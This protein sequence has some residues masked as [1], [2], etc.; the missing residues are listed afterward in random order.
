MG[1]IRFSCLA[2]LTFLCAS[3]CALSAEINLL[4]LSEKT[5]REFSNLGELPANQPITVLRVTSGHVPDV[6][7]P[8]TPGSVESQVEAFSKDLKNAAEARALSLVVRL[9]VRTDADLSKAKAS[10]VR[11][12]E[13]LEASYLAPEGRY[14]AWLDQL[15]RIAPEVYTR[16]F[17]KAVDR[18]LAKA[19]DLD[20]GALLNQEIARLDIVSLVALIRLISE[21]LRDLGVFKFPADTST[22]VLDRRHQTYATAF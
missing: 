16:E 13:V 1:I 10:L 21:L 22:S 19:W 5:W 4:K 2:W 20:E 9:F 12:I 17:I 8:D 3:T 6:D 18:G 7:V 15:S 14:K 11:A